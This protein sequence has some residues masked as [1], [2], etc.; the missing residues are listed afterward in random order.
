MDVLLEASVN[1][2]TNSPASF[3]FANEAIR[4]L[5]G[6]TQW[7]EEFMV[8]EKFVQYTSN[9]IE[10]I[11]YVKSDTKFTLSYLALVCYLY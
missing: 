2:G 5:I 4:L 9:M 11:K 10:H 7:T 3:R 8:E 1:I 6:A